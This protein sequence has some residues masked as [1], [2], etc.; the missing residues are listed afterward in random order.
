MTHPV[1]DPFHTGLVQLT[2]SQR[3]MNADMFRSRRGPAPLAPTGGHGSPLGGMAG[4][5]D[6]VL[7]AAGYTGGEEDE[8]ESGDDR[9]PLQNDADPPTQGVHSIGGRMI[10]FRAQPGGIVASDLGDSGGV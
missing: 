3:L 6:E 4:S 8:G 10:H 5:I 2:P 1:T 9:E 7:H